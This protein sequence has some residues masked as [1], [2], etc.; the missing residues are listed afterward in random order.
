MKSLRQIIRE[1][2]DNPD[3]KEI[4]NA[5]VKTKREMMRASQR[6]NQD[7]REFLKRKLKALKQAKG[8]K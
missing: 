8:E 6:A 7:V 3:P 2:N 1:V 5:I 4:E